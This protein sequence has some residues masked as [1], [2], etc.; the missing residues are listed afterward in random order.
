MAQ[1]CNRKTEAES[2]HPALSVDTSSLSE[3][4]HCGPQA[5]GW[6]A[7][8][9]C[10]RLLN[11][12]T[13]QHR[14]YGEHKLLNAAT[15][16]H[17]QYG[18][19]SPKGSGRRLGCAS[20]SSVRTPPQ[21]PHQVLTAPVGGRRSRTSLP[22]QEGDGGPTAARDLVRFS[23]STLLCIILHPARSLEWPHTPHRRGTHIC[24]GPRVQSIS[25][26]A[27]SPGTGKFKQSCLC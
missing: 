9:P 8:E 27:W 21:L 18:E 15:G 14:Q 26:R 11:A 7:R 23:G 3:N 13:G 6:Q 20:P 16:R 5:K 12:A 2:L 19:H 24:T 1:V 4:H 10:R 17:R 25:H 22:Q